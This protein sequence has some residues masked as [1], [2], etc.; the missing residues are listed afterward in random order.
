MESTHLQV[1]RIWAAM[2]WADGVIAASEAAAMKRLIAGT[3]ELSDNERELALGFLDKKV[4]LDTS[5]LAAMSAPAREGIYRAA[6]RLSMI[7]GT[8]AD[9][10]TKLLGRLREGLGISEEQAGAIRASATPAKKK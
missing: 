2:A 7:D 5:G 10:E 4:D 3:P 1:I 8:V 6:L 9:A